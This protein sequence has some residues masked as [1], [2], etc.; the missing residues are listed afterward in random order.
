[1]PDLCRDLRRAPRLAG[2]RRRGRSG[3]PHRPEHPY[4]AQITVRWDEAPEGQGPTGHAIRS[5]FSQVVADI[6]ED[7]RFAPWRSYA[8]TC[9]FRSSVAF[10]LT[11]RGRTFGALNLYSDQPG[12]FT[13][14]LTDTFQALAHQ[15]AA[16]LEN[17]RL[18]DDA[19]R[20]LRRLQALRTIDL[21]ITATLK[22]HH[23]IGVLLD[24]LLAEVTAQLEVDAADVLLYDQKAAALVYAAGY[25]F[26]SQAIEHFYLRLDEGYAGR[27]ALERRAIGIGDLTQVQDFV[28]VSLV[29]EE[30]FVAYYAAPLIAKGQVLGVLETFHR[31]AHSTNGEWLEFLEA[32]AGQVA[33]AIENVRLYQELE[34]YAAE[35]ERRVAERT[36]ELSQREAALEAANEELRRAHEELSQALA[37]ERELNELKTRFISLVSHEFRTPLTTI[38]SSAELLEHYGARWPDER[39]LTHLQ[40]IEEAV[41]RMTAL[42]D[43]VLTLGR[44]EAG[45]LTYEPR[46][47]DLV[48]FCRE[49]VDE[50]QLGMGAQHRLVLELVSSESEQEGTM[51]VV[52]DPQLV[53]H[54]LANLLSN[55]IKYSPIGSQVRLTVRM[56]GEQAIFQVTDEG[57]G[58]PAADL[59]RLFEPFHRAGNVGATSGTGLGLSIVKRMVEL[60]GGTIGV[61]SEEGHGSTFTVALPAHS[62]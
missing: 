56:A 19:L 39:K 42:V 21:A 36:V 14:E 46:P 60:C 43:D 13:P 55:A 34:A 23:P 35:L 12:F 4:P 58:I 41:R 52:M 20:R 53:R 22:P 45:R 31:G 38:L 33:I 50:F 2:P 26:Q 27:A 17:A 28:R 25:G 7:S 24:T 15:A 59:P 5:G 9:D 18:Y 37:Q 40:R 51:P 54:I 6:A 29:Q 16:A 32:L 48:G 11:S 3:H 10:P 30:G 61:A 1:M 8:E 47:L 62:S 44:T 57:I 49:L